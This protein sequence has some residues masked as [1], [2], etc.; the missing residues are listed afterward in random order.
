MAS[1]LLNSNLK[2]L[3]IRPGGRLRKQTLPFEIEQ[4]WLDREAQDHPQAIRILN[5]LQGIAVDVV[6][7]V[8]ALKR[9]KNIQ[10]AKHQLI[11]TLHR[12]E[13]FKPCQ[14][15]TSETLC[16]NYR[17]IDLISGCP[18]DCSY[19]ILQNYLSNN[20]ITTIYVNLETILAQVS[21]FLSAHSNK[22]FRI[23]TGELSDSL[24]LDSILEY[25]QVLIPFFAARRNA[26]LELKTKTAQIDHVL[27]LKHRNR[28]VLAWSV[29]TP[30]VIEKEERGTAS[31][32][33]RL[34][35]A[36][37]AARAG[38]GVAFHFDPIILTHGIEDVDSYLD[39]IEKIFATLEP[40]HIAWISLGLLRYPPELID[41]AL[42]RFPETKIFAG[43]FVP[44]RS[45]VRYLRFLREEAYRRLWEKLS[46]R[47]P[48]HKLYLCM[49]TKTVWGKIDPS[50][51]S[52]SCI[53]KRLC[54]TEAIS[55]DCFG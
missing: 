28:T 10:D 4:I 36:Q 45:K 39:V 46:L 47:L 14:G 48:A 49:E 35:A 50:I 13:A 9:P 31:L 42:R 32:A 55:F 52:N 5:R 44:A 12:G 41:T 23:G 30:T 25:A 21:A 1:T 33:E 37:R 17:V 40:R 6:D 26:I 11:L 22:F 29:N 3:P 43:E 8:K 51:T 53:E 2:R 18:M 20:P 7:N 27:E 34:A 15:M 38:F 24:A 19:C 16:C 54:N